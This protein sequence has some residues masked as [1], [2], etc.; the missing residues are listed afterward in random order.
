MYLL[1]FKINMTSFL[2]KKEMVGK[3]ILICLLLSDGTTEAK[4]EPD[5]D[6]TDMRIFPGTK[7]LT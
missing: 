7:V 5:N 1:P 3:F 2:R 6:I 4:S